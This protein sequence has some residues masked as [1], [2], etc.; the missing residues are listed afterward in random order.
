MNPTKTPKKIHSQDASTR[1]DESVVFAS[2]TKHPD[3]LK[4]DDEILSKSG[5]WKKGL[6]LLHKDKGY[7]VCIKI[8][9]LTRKNCEKEK[10]MAYVRGHHKGERTKYGTYP[11]SRFAKGKEAGQ[12]AER[13]RI[14]EMIDKFKI[15]ALFNKS[16]ENI[17]LDINWK[18]ELKKE[19][20]R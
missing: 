11:N 19:I 5:Y 3:T 7:D 10:K 16:N 20:E 4:S 15:Y 1:K 8:I 12:K 14:L 17:S 9:A 18:E 13:E 2:R 6:H